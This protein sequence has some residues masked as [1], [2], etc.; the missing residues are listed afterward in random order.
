M[1]NPQ[2]LNNYQYAL[3]NPLRYIDRNGLYEED[4]HR[5]LTAVL[6]MAAGFDEQ[7]ANAVAASDQ[8]VDDSYISARRF[9]KFSSI[10]SRDPKV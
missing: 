4:V 5:D 6:A 1:P 9:G 7:T 10:V 2:T 8:G 3:K